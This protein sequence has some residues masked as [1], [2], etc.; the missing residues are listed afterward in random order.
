M[1]LVMNPPATAA[2]TAAGTAVR[3]VV[4]ALALVLG[5]TA[6][7]EAQIAPTL[8]QDTLGGKAL[9]PRSSVPAGAVAPTLPRDTVPAAATSQV[10]SEEERTG[11]DTPVPVPSGG[12]PAS[13][14]LLRAP[15][16]SLAADTVATPRPAPARRDTTPPP[17]A[18]PAAPAG[19]DTTAA[20][21]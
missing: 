18:A 19:R 4:L 15:Q 16:D 1:T 10:P 6:A 21:R 20:P 7:L 5:T 14:P 11:R 9:E 8:P 2:R 17:L 13:R 3:A 12:T